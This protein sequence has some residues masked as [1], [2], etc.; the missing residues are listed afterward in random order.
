MWTGG[1]AGGSRRWETRAAAAVIALAAVAFANGLRGAFVFD[2]L[3]AILNNPDV[4]MGWSPLAQRSQ[5]ET[6]VSG[7]PIPTWT[8]AWNY[9]CGG[10]D[11]W[12]F[13][14]VNIAIHCAAAGIL[15]GLIRRTLAGPVL[16]PGWGDRATVVA[17]C[18]AAI[19]AVHPLQTECV[20]YIVQRVESLCGLFYLLTL[21]GVARA[22]G[23]EARWRWVAIIAC[24]AGMA[25]KEVMV[26][27]PIAAVLL[28]RAFWGGSFAAVWR[29][30]RG[31]HVALAAT[32]LLLAAILVGSPRGEST[33][34]GVPFGWWEYA[35]TQP[36]VILHYLRLTFWPDRLVL[37]YSWP[38]SAAGFA[39]A[40]QWAAVV[41]LAGA[42][43]Y[44]LARN[45]AWGFLLFVGLLILAPSSSVYPILD[46]AFEHR[47]YLPLAPVAIG[48]A[49]MVCCFAARIHQVGR[50]AERLA[51]LLCIPVVALLMW[52]TV[53][54]NADYA[55]PIGLWQKNL[56]DGG[57]EKP[58]V[59]QNLSA[60]FLVAGRNDEARDAA[61]YAIRC[62]KDYAEAYGNLCAACLATGRIDEAIEAGLNA[63]RIDPNL[64]T[65]H[66]NLSR[67]L[68]RAG[69]R[70]E[71]SAHL[72]AALRL[73]PNLLENI[74]PETIV[75]PVQGVPNTLAPQ[76][77]D[78]SRNAR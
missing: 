7:R 21:Y 42:G 73:N 29:Q 68:A 18:A 1:H 66:L 8:L 38:V 19:W 55:D 37:D 61:I 6:T 27:A 58:R 77:A 65:V 15:F 36:A 52:R 72:A 11:P 59:W 13:H 46:A 17:A 57:M 54:R 26:T 20:T 40:G 70:E 35:R 10:A 16:G 64:A 44:G 24:A 34:S 22:A 30:R 69:R 51:M 60:S 62:S 32:W 53:H 4:T 56:V 71:S 14:V 12:G 5:I 76:K 47:M 41:G 9:A 49:V 28:D 33:G 39:T 3:G 31:L 50:R 67:A 2:D 74:E 23:G 78:Q 63:V 43:L 45:R 25:T 75:D 48:A